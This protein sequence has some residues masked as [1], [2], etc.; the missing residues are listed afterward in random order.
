MFKI[1]ILN[2]GEASMC[3]SAHVGVRGQRVGTDS[4]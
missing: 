1:F 3:W 2:G 4:F